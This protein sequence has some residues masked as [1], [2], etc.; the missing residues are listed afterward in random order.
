MHQLFRRRFLLAASTALMGASGVFF[1]LPAMAAFD[2]AADQYQAPTRTKA[3]PD[4]QVLTGEP[5]RPLYAPMAIPAAVAPQYVAPVS[6]IQMPRPL[7]PTRAAAPVAAPVVAPAAVAAPAAPAVIAPVPA[8]ASTPVVAEPVAVASPAPVI[9]R[10]PVIA[11]QPQPEPIAPVVATAAPAVLAPIP[12][13]VAAPVEVARPVPVVAEPVAP[14]ATA[15]FVAP[16]PLI[17]PLALA[18]VEAAP[19]VEPIRLKEPSVVVPQ[20]IRPTVPETTVAAVAAPEPV[21]IVAP[22][23][24]VAE[25]TVI[26]PAPAILASDDAPVIANEAVVEVPAYPHVDPAVAERAQ[27]MLRAEVANPQPIVIDAPAPVVASAPMA[28]AAA[29][30]ESTLSP[31]TRAILGQIPSRMDS[32]P[33][34]KASKTTLNRVSPEIEGILGAPVKEESFESVGLSI[35]VRRPGLDTNYELNNAYNALMGG[36]TPR[37][38]EIYRNI[39]SVEPRNEDAL[40]GLAA[41]YH[42]L[43]QTNQA[44]PFYGALLKQNPNHREGLNNFLVLVGEESPADALPELERLQ[45][46]NPEFSPIPAQIAIVLDRMGYPDRAED[47]MLRAIEL[48]PENMTYKY[49]LAVMLDQHARYSDATAMYGMLIQASLRGEHVPATLDS[50]QRR[51][52]FLTTAMAD[53]RLGG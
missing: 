1:A 25:P 24:Q 2:P 38:I 41:T 31:Q 36:D 9:A 51:L 26:A 13:P 39:L 11:L 33:V 20:T 22:V 29:P 43:G 40:F 19:V 45:D 10:V 34:A 32:T 30:V 4:T 52:N 3:L 44:R 46:R 21:A 23:A 48:A 14:V 8:F 12:T 16:A 35:K 49:N 5:V 7:Y 28:V 50:M 27:A 42:R 47:A 18:P 37:A 53:G 6:T 17:A 15:G